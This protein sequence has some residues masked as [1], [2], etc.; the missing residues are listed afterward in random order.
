[1]D[2][3]GDR[4]QGTVGVV[5]ALAGLLDAAAQLG[6]RRLELRSLVPQLRRH[7][8]ERE[9]ELPDLVGSRWGDALV[10]ITAGDRL[11]AGGQLADRT[12]DSPGDEGG[13]ET[14]DRQH[15]ERQPGQLPARA[16]DLRLHSTPGQ[17]NARRAPLLALHEHRHGDVVAAL[18]ARADHRFLDEQALRL[19]GALVD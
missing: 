8:I 9:G 13:P 15:D 5:L 17:S 4:A 10:E 16:V 11:G 12:R 19:G 2:A 18:A 1:G 6:V 3:A 14:T 7:V